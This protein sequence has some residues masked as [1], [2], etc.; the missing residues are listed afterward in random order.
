MRRRTSQGPASANLPQGSAHFPK[1]SQVG[2]LERDFVRFLDRKG[3]YP[4]ICLIP[5]VP[6]G[7][8]IPSRR[9]CNL[10]YVYVRKA[11]GKDDKQVCAV[12]EEK[13]C[14]TSVAH[15]ALSETTKSNSPW[16]WGYYGKREGEKR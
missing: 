2:A 9:I 13:S 15:R 7:S 10:Q 14:F 4:K 3:E 16:F 11:I 6:S 1:K 8:A 12:S 5:V